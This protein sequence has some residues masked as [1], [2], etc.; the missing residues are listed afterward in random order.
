MFRQ[1]NRLWSKFSMAL[2]T[3]RVNGSVTLDGELLTNRTLKFI[4]QETGEEQTAQVDE[5]GNYAQVL[6]K[7]RLYT[8]IYGDQEPY[9]RIF[10]IPPVDV[11]F[12]LLSP[13]KLKDSNG[14]DVLDSEGKN[15]YVQQNQSV[16]L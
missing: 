6:K 14:F 13:L 15:I 10:N 11:N 5:N 8:L 3:T 4:C 2:Y 7:G 12:E 1:F 9:I 16:I